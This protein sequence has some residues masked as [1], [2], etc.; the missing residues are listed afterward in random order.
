M[1][2]TI[3]LQVA[4][5]PCKA[6]IN[7]STN[8]VVEVTTANDPAFADLKVAQAMELAKRPPEEIARATGWTRE[9]DGKWAGAW[10]HDPGLRTHGATHQIAAGRRPVAR[11][12][13]MD[14]AIITLWTSGRLKETGLD[15][16]A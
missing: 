11:D 3:E 9:E 15:W 13:E 14:Q 8:K 2:V 10:M 16:A 12:R 1:L 4:D 7:T 5:T 6:T